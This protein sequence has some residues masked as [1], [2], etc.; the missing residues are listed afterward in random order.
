MA[1]AR[2]KLNE[3]YR[4]Y[5]EGQRGKTADVYD[6]YKDNIPSTIVEEMRLQYRSAEEYLLPKVE[7][8]NEEKIRLQVLLDMAKI[9][10]FP[11]HKLRRLEEVMTRPISFEEGLAEFRKLEE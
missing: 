3:G 11:E 5:W 7:R 2:G 4:I 8:T 10:G 9:Q 6:L 1:V